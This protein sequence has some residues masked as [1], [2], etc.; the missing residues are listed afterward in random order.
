ML[1]LGRCILSHFLRKSHALLFFNSARRIRDQVKIQNWVDDRKCFGEDR[2][3]KCLILLT[4][5]SWGDHRETN[6]F[7]DLGHFLGLISDQ[8]PI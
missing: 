6:S 7:H 3:C 8:A 2:L 1:P 5:L 4:F